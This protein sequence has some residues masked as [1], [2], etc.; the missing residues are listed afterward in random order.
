MDAL[1]CT[2]NI[3]TNY[4]A[5]FK[6]SILPVKFTPQHFVDVQKPAVPTWLRWMEASKEH[7]RAGRDLVANSIENILEQVIGL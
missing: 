6:L 1:Q 2:K 4:L 3:V 7:G 5:Q